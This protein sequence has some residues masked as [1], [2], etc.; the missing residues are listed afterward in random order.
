MPLPLLM[1]VMII[2]PFNSL[3]PMC[4]AC[5]FR[6]GACKVQVMIVKP[7]PE[8][9]L[10]LRKATRKAPTPCIS[11]SPTGGHDLTSSVNGRS[12]QRSASGTHWIEGRAVLVLRQQHNILMQSSK[13]GAGLS[14]LLLEP[15]WGTCPRLELLHLLLPTAYHR[16]LQY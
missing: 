15:V 9:M 7:M 13:A 8:Q 1:K 2:A 5:I 14:H 10:A 6:A 12:S 3:T 16:I 4:K 11:I